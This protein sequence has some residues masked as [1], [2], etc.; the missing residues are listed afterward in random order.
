M[1]DT[2]LAANEQR[3]VHAM[4]VAADGRPAPL[5]PGNVVTWASS[6]PSALTVEVDFVNQLNATI[7]SANI[8]GT[9]T[10]TVEG[11]SPS[12]AP[13]RGTFTVL[14]N[15]PAPLEADH[16]AFTFEEPEP[17]T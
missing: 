10:V 11:T 16:F 5:A 4:S 1:A 13:V 2:T 3:V 6:D 14:I 9:V 15:V 12:G 17:R 8:N 7:K